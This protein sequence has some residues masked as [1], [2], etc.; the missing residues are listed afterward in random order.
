MLRILPPVPVTDCV[1]QHHVPC[2]WAHG[3]CRITECIVRAPYPFGCLVVRGAVPY[4]QPSVELVVAF[5]PMGWVMEGGNHWYNV[6]S[7]QNPK[8][9]R[10]VVLFAGMQIWKPLTR[11]VVAHVA[12]QYTLEAGKGTCKHVVN[13]T[14]STG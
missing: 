10:P 11:N 4:Y 3:F 7:L 8:V 1:I 14:V 9:G 12:L 6:D 13:V 5:A 2:L